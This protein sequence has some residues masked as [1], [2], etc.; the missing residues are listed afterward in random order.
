[1]QDKLNELNSK[2]KQPDIL[3]LMLEKEENLFIFLSIDMCNSTKMKKSITNWFDVTQT[4]Y[5]ERFNVMHFWK[6]NGDEV[7]YAEP[8][9]NIDNLVSII[10]GAY[11]H[12]KNMQATL[13]SV[14]KIKDFKLKGAIWIARTY[15]DVSSTQNMHFCINR[16]TDEFLG[17]NIDEGFRLSKKVSGSKIVID[18]KI[19][20]LLL[21]VDDI[22]R[23]KRKYSIINDTHDFYQYAREI[24]EKTN[25]KLIDLLDTVHFI[26][27][28]KLKGVWNERGY[29][30]FWLYKN[31]DDDF[32]YDEQLDGH[33][34]TP[35]KLLDSVME[36]TIERIFKSV[37]T[38]NEF[39]K[40]LSLIASGKQVKIYTPDDVSRLYYTIACVNPNTNSVLVF[41]RSKERRHLKNVWE[42][43]SFKHS[44][45]LISDALEKKYK[46]VFGIDIEIITDGEKEKNILPMHFCTIHRNGQA[47]NSILCF[48]KIKTDDNIK[49]DKD[50]ITLIKKHIK[51]EDYSDFKFVNSADLDN[52]KS[53]TLEE[54]SDDSMNALSER[55][56]PFPDNTAVM[57]FRKSVMAA[58]N[59]FKNNRSGDDWF[60]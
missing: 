17:I 31:G 37:E 29:P 60:K 16:T 21:L 47:H 58:E 39:K 15:G 30:V 24:N 11:E 34:S 45:V 6:Y 28:T 14:S 22:A 3:N 33:Y 35:E 48:A 54:I 56:E 49:S 43:G 27:Y 23:Y 19:I 12:I 9:S 2:V 26:D 42:F 46:D 44:S 5:N 25:K 1:M 55:A 40:I 7:L 18:P 50:I 36:T 41:L 20:Y 53:V 59:F 4:F 13:A 51:K 52:Y 38:E 10:D 57:Y 32:E 8:F